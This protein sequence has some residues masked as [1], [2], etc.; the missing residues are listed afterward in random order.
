MVMASTIELA[1]DI[2][3]EFHLRIQ[4]QMKLRAKEY[5]NSFLIYFG[6][7]IYILQLW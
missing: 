7:I 6:F 3:S 1:C 2:P 4:E 5:K